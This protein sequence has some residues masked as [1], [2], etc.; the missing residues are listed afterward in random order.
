LA[1]P[2]SGFDNV[3]F[4]QWGTPQ[5]TPNGID[6]IQQIRGLA[7]ATLQRGTH[8]TAG[9]IQTLK[10]AKWDEATR[11]ATIE[12]FGGAN[13]P[14]SSGTWT[15]PVSCVWIFL[16]NLGRLCDYTYVFQF[17]EDYRT[18]QIVPK[19]NCTG[20]LLPC[21]PAW[22]EVP[23][24]CVVTSFENFTPTSTHFSTSQ[25][26]NAVQ[27]PESKHGEHWARNSSTCGSSYKFSY[28][29][30]EVFDVD[31][32]HAKYYDDFKKYCPEKIM[33]AR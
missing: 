8:V 3:C 20:C 22:F 30:V 7:G 10:W 17:S 25:G 29:L 16:S 23:T 18:T 9:S 26:F 28:D 31:G 11:T 27:A 24:N 14:S 1:P 2:P 13:S 32:K 5:R 4:C 33:I 21:V 15:E 19:I 12:V 6:K